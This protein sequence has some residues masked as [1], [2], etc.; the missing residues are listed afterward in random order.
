MMKITTF[1]VALIIGIVL[2]YF[3]YDYLRKLEDCMCAQGM[4]QSEDRRADITKLKY[5]ELLLLVIALANFFFAFKNKLTPLLSTI[6]FFFMIIVYIMFIMNVVKLYNNIPTD[7][8]CA[9][10]WPRYYIYLQSILMT[11]VLITFFIAIFLFVYGAKVM[12]GKM[13]KGRK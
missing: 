2:I 13:I 1:T 5:I 4:F 9:I 12:K 7:C 10:Q 8:E 6:F 3:A 11:F